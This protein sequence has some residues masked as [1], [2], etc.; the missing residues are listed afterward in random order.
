MARWWRRSDE[1]TVQDPV[2]VILPEPLAGEVRVMLADDRY[3]PAV[4]LVRDRTA[5]NLLPAVLAVNRIRD[6]NAVPQ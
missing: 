6:D 3:V 2:A 1:S 4:K 5:L